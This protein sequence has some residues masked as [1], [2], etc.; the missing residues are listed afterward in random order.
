LPD[1]RLDE[2][3]IARLNR[4]NSLSLVAFPLDSRRMDW[5][6]TPMK[7]LM[8]MMCFAGLLPFASAEDAAPKR[9]AAADAKSHVGETATVC[10][11]VVDTK[12]PKY[13]I[14]GHG[15]PVSFDL[16]Q[17]EPNPIFYFVAFGSKAGDAGVQEVV[18]AYKG[19]NVCVTGKISQMPTGGA[20]LIMAADRAK[21]EVQ[22]DKK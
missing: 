4:G 15:K 12:V 17:P 3:R 7:M 6:P 16:D 1:L 2:S 19:K 11:K 14:A 8:L 18:D 20:P 21:I 5:N 13:G 10:G 9:V 22:P